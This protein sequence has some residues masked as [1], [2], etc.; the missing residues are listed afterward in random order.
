M[1]VGGRYLLS[2]PMGQGPS[3]VEIRVR[4][5][6]VEVWHHEHCGGIL[7]RGILQDWLREPRGALLTDEVSLVALRGGHVAVELAGHGTWTLNAR[8]V[9]DLH[10][11]I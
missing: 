1:T 11:A 8:A 5:D 6:F 3:S 10:A 2:L 9:A 4:P 7:D